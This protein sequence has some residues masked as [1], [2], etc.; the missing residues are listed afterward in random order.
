MPILLSRHNLL[1]CSFILLKIKRDGKKIKYLIEKAFVI[2]KLQ[3]SF[4]M[5]EIMPQTLKSDRCNEPML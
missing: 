2:L 4:F 5:Q 1:P 3:M